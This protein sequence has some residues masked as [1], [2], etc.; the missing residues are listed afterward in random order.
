MAIQTCTLSFRDGKTVSARIK[1]RYAD[2]DTPVKYSGETGRL[3]FKYKRADAMVLRAIFRSF[4][5]ELGA[6][7]VEELLGE[8]DQRAGSNPVVP[9]FSPPPKP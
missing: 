5:R 8:W 7:F 2:E 3:P 1:A 4:A 9:F 6:Q